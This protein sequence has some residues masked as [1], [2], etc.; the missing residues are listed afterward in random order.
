MSGPDSSHPLRPVP[1]PA[2]ISLAA[3]S[4][5]VLVR[6]TPGQFEDVCRL[7]NANGMTLP[8]VLRAG[9]QV[10]LTTEAVQR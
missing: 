6:L 7:A 1:A 9:L 2:P 4:K 8:D 10:L 3:K 5:P